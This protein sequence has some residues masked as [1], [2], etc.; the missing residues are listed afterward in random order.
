MSG[1]YTGTTQ[2]TKRNTFSRLMM[3]SA[4][5][6]A[7]AFVI[8]SPA[9]ASGL[10]TGESLERGAATFDRSIADTLNI[11]QLSERLVINW[12][13]FDIDAGKTVEFFQ[14][15]SD[16][17]LAVN[18]VL[19]GDAFTKINGTLKANQRVMIL[20]PNGVLFGAGS[21]VDV[22]S[23]VASTGDV[24][25]DEVASGTQQIHLNNI[26]GT[27]SVI[28]NG[29]ITARN[30]GLTALVAANVE[31]SGVIS[32]KLGK[33]ALA[34][35]NTTATLD[36]YGDGLVE[37][38]VLDDAGATKVKNSGTVKGQTV[39]MTASSAKS[40]VDGVVNTSGVTNASTA[41]V[42]GGKIILS[43]DN[44]KIRKNANIKGNTDITAKTVKLGTTI[45][46]E[47]TGSAGTVYVT[48]DTAKIN[49]ALDI[50]DE[51]GLVDV[52]AGTY[53]EDVVV[54][55][56]G[57]TLKG[58]KS[59]IAGYN[60]S[61]DGT[62]E[63][64]ITPHS[65]GVVVAANNVTVDG[66]T[67]DGA[68]NGIEVGAFSGATLKN[69]IIKNSAIAAGSGYT[70]NN[71]IYL[72]GASGTDILNNYILNT[73]DAYAPYA[74]DASPWTHGSGIRADESHDILID[75]NK[76]ENAVWDGVK[77]ENGYDFIV[78]NNDI[79][80]VGRVGVYG[81]NPHNVQTTN[82]NINNADM[83]GV[84]FIGGSYDTISGNTI[85]DTKLEGV[86][87]HY[88]S[89]TKNILN[90]I[91]NNTGSHGI[92]LLGS[93][94]ALIQG[95]EI[96]LLGGDNNIQGDNI[97]VRNSALTRVNL[98]KL[99]EAKSTA[100][101]VGSGVHLYESDGS[102]ASNNT[103]FGTEWDGVKV[104]RGTDI[105]VTGNDIDD[106]ARVGVYSSGSRNT[107]ASS[108]TINGADLY[109]IRLEGLEGIIDA[110]YN[111]IADVVYDGISI[112]SSSGAKNI[113]GNNIDDVGGHGIYTTYA[114]DANISGN[115]IGTHG[116]AGN[117]GG[118][119]IF[120]E[121]S[122]NNTI[123]GNTVK[124]TAADGVRVRNSTKKLVVSGNTINA[125]GDNGVE[126]SNA[127]DDVTVKDNAVTN[128]GNNGLEVSGGDFDGSINL[129]VQNNT[130]GNSSNN[131]IYL[132][133]INGDIQIIGNNQITNS[134]NNGIY[135]QNVNNGYFMAPAFALLAL[136]G[137][138]TSDVVIE[139][140][141]YPT[142]IGQQ[143]IIDGN[144][145]DMSSNDGISLYNVS[146]LARISQN[147][148][149]N[150]GYNGIEA[151]N[152][153]F[154][155][156]APPI[157]EEAILDEG[158]AFAKAVFREERTYAPINLYIVD[159]TI[160]NTGLTPVETISEAKISSSGTGYAAVSLDIG[161]AGSAKLAGNT[162]GSNFIYGLLGYSGNIDLTGRT[163]TIHDTNIGMGF[164]PSSKTPLFETTEEELAYFDYL[165]NRLHL[166]N[167][168]I[169]TTEFV[170]QSQYFVDL[171]Y[172]AFFAPGFPTLLDG[173]NAT[174]TLGTA[175][176]DPSATGFVTVGEY[177]TL[178]NMIYHY[179]DSQDRGLFFFNVLTPEGQTIDQK[180]FFRDF[181]FSGPQNLGGSL[182][183]TGLPSIGGGNNVNVRGGGAPVPFNLN[184]IAPAAGEEED[185]QQNVA[186][187][188][189]AS[190][191]GANDTSC[192]S[193]ASQTLGQGTPVTFNFGASANSLL[194]NTATCGNGQNL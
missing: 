160:E 17:A 179:V 150:S 141:D 173:M 6:A 22:G 180:D 75:G 112:L 144:N 128:S 100:W 89:G 56:A 189:P 73:G 115:A 108:N 135:A 35:G 29:S 87:V 178:E 114:G 37:L 129:L 134:G 70:T 148:I 91:I 106:V 186:D 83:Y 125:A 43:A 39:L 48:N 40:V 146:G 78:S 132:S 33:V 165:A 63:T 139:D 184:D 138:E 27:G 187:I 127:T 123:A 49:Q 193:D 66:L 96:G 82:N 120:V 14:P 142:N 79:D 20:D 162:M 9:M 124:N 64:I 47:V 103:I 194:Q 8:S 126:L 36:L 171:G 110:S 60:V 190:G 166:V 140:T 93:S 181:Q 97:L 41:K 133:Y 94:G 74:T 72:V 185:A 57:V 80:N 51:T 159:N 44:V 172:G 28:N 59:G 92:D 170:D 176:I 156:Y 121:N 155:F 111:I 23:I 163:N 31:N 34:A 3:T 161:S 151:Y 85:N 98:N 168:T 55:V 137:G 71:G 95:N 62:G 61:R 76:I 19:N 164:Y 4:L 130:I 174:Y 131:G 13:S 21:I 101:E 68:N 11:N 107:T 42:V 177:A 116:V 122:A 167:D 86:S 99:S 25:L 1:F 158:F 147:T 169:G 38:A 24:D 118:A 7:G 67:I 136:D 143:L 152:S 175:T 46:G 188:Q 52:A 191:E 145:I 182:L 16:R 154:G 50:I 54:D 90:N 45:K 5:V 84:R 18:R 153:D 10:P 53:N 58:A 105:S 30:T 77:I 12:S 149:T 69:N 65:P 2:K 32:A 109:G 117:I 102:S 88:V 157:L 15:D 113:A 104:T 26:G 81:S 183:I 192:W 119:G